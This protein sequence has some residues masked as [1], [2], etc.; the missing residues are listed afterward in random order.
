MVAERATAKAF[1]LG[2]ISLL[3][4]FSAYSAK[5]S[6]SIDAPPIFGKENWFENASDATFGVSA[7][8]LA[9]SLSFFVS[10]GFGFGLSL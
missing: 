9:V 1:D 8:F 4:D 10:L 6:I 5:A 3:D 2:V 7:G